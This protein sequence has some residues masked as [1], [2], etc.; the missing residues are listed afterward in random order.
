VERQTLENKELI[1]IAMMNTVAIFKTSGCST[2]LVIVVNAKTN[3]IT[4]KTH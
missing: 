4:M 1:T 3:E 2:T